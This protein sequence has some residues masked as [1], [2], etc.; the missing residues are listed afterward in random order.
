MK[1]NVLRDLQYYKFCAYGF[2]K[3]LKFFDPFFI[4][5]LIYKGLP[6]IQI[7]LLYSLR[8]VLVNIFEIPSGFFADAMGRKGAM[9]FSF[10]SYIIS[11]AGFYFSR[12]FY[13]LAFAM[14]FFALGDAFRTGTHKAMIYEYLRIKNIQD[15]KVHYY[16]HT[17]SASLIGT[18]LSA[19][20]GSAI[21]F[22]TRSLETIFLFSIIPYVL[23]LLLIMSYPGALNGDIKKLELR[24]IIDRFALILSEIKK[25]FSRRK[26]FMTLANTSMF[27]GYYQAGK[28][29]IQPILKSFAL[30]MPVFFNLENEQRTALVIGTTYFLLYLLTSIITRNAGTF[31]DRIKKISVSLNITFILGFTGGIISGIF[32][33][34]NMFYLSVIFF[35]LIIFNENLRRPI[36]LGY[37]TEI[38][39]SRIYATAL[40]VES[41]MKALFAAGFAFLLGLFAELFD[42]GIAIIMTAIIGILLFPVLRIRSDQSENI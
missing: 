36:G 35:I 29:Y 18:A 39:D 30:A 13:T 4:L 12:D 27:S 38:L 3:N 24:K 16:G 23:G 6:F 15:Q 42:V 25:A 34:Y 31:A 19:L 5:F 1:Q 14:A 2:L 8:E 40:S 26:T 37:F 32:Y 17:R 11:F 33:H 41:Q 20:I 22:Y 7:G 21:V 28:D 10:I 9:I